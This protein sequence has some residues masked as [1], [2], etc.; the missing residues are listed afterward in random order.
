MLVGIT[1][2]SGSGKSTFTSLLYKALLPNVILLPLDNYYKSNDYFKGKDA[3]QINFD[4]PDCMDFELLKKNIQ[5]LREKGETAIPVYDM[6]QHGRQGYQTIKTQPL[7]LLEGH[8]LFAN[9]SIRELLD[10]K[11]FIHT[12]ADIRLI[13]RLKRDIQERKRTVES[14]TYQYLHHVR[15]M[16][17]QFIAPAQELADIVIDGMSPFKNGLIN[18]VIEKLKG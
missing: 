6:Q 13:R 7:I 14:V 4:H 2:G 18:D 15:P 8:L 17:E 11:I 9:P 10:V 5:E 3:H 1:G 16:H 12:P